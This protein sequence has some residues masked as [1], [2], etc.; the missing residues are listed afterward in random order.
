MRTILLP[1]TAALLLVRAAGAQEAPPPPAVPTTT[2]A[3]SPVPVQDDAVYNDGFSFGFNLDRFHDDFGM[4]GQV[5]TPTFA[6]DTFRITA[7][8]GLTWYTGA[9]NGNGDNVWLPYY[10]G[11]LVFEVGARLKGTPIRLY[12]VSGVVAIFTPSRLAGDVVHPGGYGGFGFEFYMPARHD[13]GR[14]KDGP[15]SYMIELGGIGTGTQADNLPGKPIIANGFL[16]TVGLR[17]YP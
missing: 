10:H 11:R 4:T 2:P 9:T 15:V 3:S 6:R 13:D 5:S 1:L 12:G 7:G 8:G 17:V 14:T 16:A